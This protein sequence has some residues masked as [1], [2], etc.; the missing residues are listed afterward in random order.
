MGG[1]GP[2]PKDLGQRRNRSVPRRGDW[3]LLPEGDSRGRRPLPR[4]YP[5]GGYTAS[6]KVEWARWW[7][8][9]MAQMW[10]E[11]DLGTIEMLLRLID[12]WWRNPTARASNEIRL[13]K[14]SLGLSPKGRQDRRWRLPEGVE[15][16]AE[17]PATVTRL[18]DRRKLATDT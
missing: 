11:S 16:L 6:A 3:V 12:G 14:D 17:V 15:D 4:P 9:P 10:D 7:K 5:K 1:K 18:A 13:T 8:S 2:P